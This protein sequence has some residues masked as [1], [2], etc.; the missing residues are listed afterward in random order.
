MVLIGYKQVALGWLA[1]ASVPLVSK[2]AVRVHID[3][4]MQHL[5]IGRVQI[6]LLKPRIQCNLRYVVYG[7]GFN[8][9]NVL[10]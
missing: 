7:I 5:H 9:V 3:L 8:L 6:R 4:I 10:V 2:S 1:G